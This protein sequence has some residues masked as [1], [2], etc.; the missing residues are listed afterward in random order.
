VFVLMHM[1][2]SR[3]EYDERTSHDFSYDIRAS[4]VYILSRSIDLLHIEPD[5]GN[6]VSLL[7]RSEAV[8]TQRK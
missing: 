5:A 4:D 7:S 1:W 3:C 6:G 8:N 2:S